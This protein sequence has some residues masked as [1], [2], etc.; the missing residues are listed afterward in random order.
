MQGD[1]E[2]Y[3]SVCSSLLMVPKARGERRPSVPL[4]LYI[5]QSHGGKT[6]EYD[7]VPLQ[8]SACMSSML[9]PGRV[10]CGM[11]VITRPYNTAGPEDMMGFLDW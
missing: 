10:A 6:S 11:I 1:A 7:L 3:A 2:Q 8:R 4:R 5:R 9:G